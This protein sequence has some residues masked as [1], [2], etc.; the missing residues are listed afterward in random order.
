MKEIRISQDFF[1]WGNIFSAVEYSFE[2]NTNKSRGFKLFYSTGTVHK[3]AVVTQTFES[4][5]FE[6]IALP[7]SILIRKK[8]KMSRDFL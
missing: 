8:C 1:W 4:V 6:V 2:R 3:S 7:S 5:H